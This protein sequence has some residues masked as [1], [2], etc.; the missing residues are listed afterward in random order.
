[1]ADAIRPTYGAVGPRN[2]ELCSLLIA[3]PKAL[4]ENIGQ[5][6]LRLLRTV[7]LDEADLLLTGE[8]ADDVTE[9]LIEGRQNN[10]AKR[11]AN[12]TRSRIA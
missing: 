3:T 2:K 12:R 11:K 4:R 8:Y 6:R 9:W 7:V 5:S 10:S 1:M